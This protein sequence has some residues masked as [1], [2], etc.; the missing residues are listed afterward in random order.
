MPSVSPHLSARSSSFALR[1]MSLP[2]YCAA[3][4]RQTRRRTHTIHFLWAGTRLQVAV[5]RSAPSIINPTA[6][7]FSVPQRRAGITTHS[8]RRGVS[9][10]K[11]NMTPGSCGDQQACFKCY[12]SIHLIHKSTRRLDTPVECVITILVSTATPLTEQ[13]TTKNSGRLAGQARFLL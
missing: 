2:L 1:R 6:D 5:P 10:L 7:L 9:K 13:S 4:K 12:F 3:D 8:K 11:W